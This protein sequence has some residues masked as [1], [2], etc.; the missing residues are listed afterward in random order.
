MPNRQILLL[1]LS[2]CLLLNTWGRGAEPKNLE[3]FSQLSD[4][5]K[6]KLL[7]KRVK[8]TDGYFQA[9]VGNYVINSEI[10]R[11][12]AYS[13]GLV[14]REFAE[15]AVDDGLFPAK[16]LGKWLPGLYLFKDK[17][18]YQSHLQGFGFNPGWSDGMFAYGNKLKSPSLLVYQSTEE[19]MREVIF[20]EGTHQLM[21]LH[22]GN[23]PTW[24]N[25]GYATNIETYDINR[26]LK[27]NLYHAM[28]VNNRA[29]GVMKLIESD[30]LIPLSKLKFVDG[31]EWSNASG[32]EVHAQYASAWLIVNYFFTCKKGRKAVV[33]L[34]STYRDHKKEPTF[35]LEELDRDI[36]EHGQ[37]TVIPCVKYGRKVFAALDGG[38]TAAAAPILET[39]EKEF[40]DNPEAKFYRLWLKL[41]TGG[42][43]KET[44][45]AAEALVKANPDFYHPALNYVLA[46]GYFKANNAAKAKDYAEK[47]R[48]DNIKHEPTLK[49]LE[50][51][52]KAARP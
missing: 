15:E 51:L 21:F 4:A 50:D 44:A 8:E 7:A 9:R 18:S 29:I 48:R 28:F 23:T 10:D 47:A 26:R 5:D 42:D 46:T 30:S 40:P 52:K 41:L 49:L 3:Q 17:G 33:K 22:V 25:E 12:S 43:A 27:A 39:M 13:W 6:E 31:K 11:E 45:T 19:R 37:K 38:D 34:L 32:K 2:A 35:N 14:L 36:K 20:H 1:L 24:F 16:P